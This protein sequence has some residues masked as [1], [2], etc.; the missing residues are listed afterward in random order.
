MLSKAMTGEGFDTALQSSYP[1]LLA[2]GQGLSSGQGINANMGQGLAGMMALQEEKER[3]QKSQT[4]AETAGNMGLSQGE[5]ALFESMDLGGRQSYLGNIMQ[6]RRAEEAARARAS[7]SA[8]NARRKAE[9]EAAEAAQRRAMYANLFGGTNPSRPEPGPQGPTIAAANAPQPPM[10]SGRTHDQWEQIYM[11]ALSNPDVSKE[12]LGRIESAMELTAPDD[13]P[14]SIVAL[15]ERADM[16]GLQPGSPEYQNFMLTGGRQQDGLSINVG[17]D[18][19]FSFNQG[20]G[21]T[22]L[23]ATAKPDRGFQR[24]WNPATQ[25]YEDS[26]IPGSP[27]ASE[28][29]KSDEQFQLAQSNFDRKSDR[30]NSAIGQ[31]I[32]ML[33]QHGRGVAGV[34]SMLSAL[35]E[36]NARTFQNVV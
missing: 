5:M 36:T 9:S 32:S 24:V 7:A 33:E 19:G 3:K 18:G 25:S 20:P 35:P 1:L 26:A 4:L 14:D 29:A 27:A 17:P 13:M 16:A 30:F 10:V 12:V 15:R 11:R 8:A 21:V 28:Q 6:Q 23:P 31:A 2:M 22:G 34:G